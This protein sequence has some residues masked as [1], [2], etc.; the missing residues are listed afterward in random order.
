M[1]ASA[2]ANTAAPTARVNNM[3]L[4]LTDCPFGSVARTARP[5]NACSTASVGRCYLLFYQGFRTVNSRRLG[6]C[7]RGEVAIAEYRVI[8]VVRRADGHP[9]AVGCSGNGNEVMY[10]DLWTIGQA[11]E[12]IEQGHRLYVVSPTSG[13]RTELDLESYDELEDLPPCG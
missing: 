3:I 5:G 9:R 11:R 10:D 12:A 4:D 8:C 1:S 6:T 2:S 7:G 13:T